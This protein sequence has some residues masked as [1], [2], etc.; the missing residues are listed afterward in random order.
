MASV[1]AG[2][3]SCHFDTP[4]LNRHGACTHIARYHDRGDCDDNKEDQCT[5]QTE[6]Y[7]TNESKSDDTSTSDSPLEEI[8]HSLLLPI[9]LPPHKHY[10]GFVGHLADLDPTLP[11]RTYWKL[12]DMYT[13]I[14]QM[15]LGMKHPRVFVGS[16]EMVNEMADDS[17]FIKHTHRLHQE[18]RAVFG[19][20]LF[21]AESTSEAWKKAHRLLVPALGMSR[22]PGT[23]KALS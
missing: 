2:P 11:V 18:M 10:Y 23:H 4:L 1:T 14:F 22:I 7:G 6:I 13:P 19:D 16:R 9:P 8:D 3:A 17:R 21:S 12:M 5:V 20:G 15:D